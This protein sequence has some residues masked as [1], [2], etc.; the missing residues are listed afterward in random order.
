M[1]GGFRPA[2]RASSVEVSVSAWSPLSIGPSLYVM[3]Y[4]S[5]TTQ[6]SPAAN[7]GYFIPLAL[8]YP[9]TVT[10]LWWVNGGA[11]AG[12]V[13][14]GI[15]AEDGTRLVSAGTTAQV[16][17][18]NVQSVD[19]TDTTLG[20][21]RYYMGLCSDTSGTT[22]RFGAIVPAVLGNAQALGL[23]E[24][25]SCAPPMSTNANPA[26]FAA[27]TRLWIPHIGFQATRVLGP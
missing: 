1:E 17:T 22:Q 7:V 9:V 3:G 8:P 11:V 2:Y 24:D 27:Y 19:V 16:G 4:T 23:L 18:T 14:M 15:F 13:D 25:A 6:N 20:R 21:G 10:K 12:N 26:T 5:P